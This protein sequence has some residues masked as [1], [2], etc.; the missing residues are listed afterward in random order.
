[1]IKVVPFFLR[2]LVVQV[3]ILGILGC[4]G[5]PNHPTQIRFAYQNRIAD[6]AA[7]VAV[8]QDSFKSQGLSVKPLR[9]DSG[10]ACAEALFTGSA[11]LGTMGDAAA[12]T[13]ITRNPD[14]AIIASHATGEHRHRL[15]VKADSPIRQPQDLAGKVVAVKK[16]TSTHGGFLT[17]LTAKGLNAASM[18]VKDLRPADVPDALFAGSVDAFVASE[19]TPSLAE[20]RGARQI[21]TMGGLGNQ[22]PIL[23]VASR[24]F[25]AKHNQE[26]VR[27]LQTLAQAEAFIRQ[28]PEP[29]AAMVAKATGL[30]PEM[31][32]A[33]MR[34]HRFDLSLGPEIVASLEHLAKFLAEQQK[35]P[36]AP[37]LSQRLDAQYLR[38]A[39]GK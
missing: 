17:Y 23:I 37:P 8:A 22:Y 39:M 31:T 36:A 13:A 7:I 25:L 14:L 26:V 20:S 30:T 6:A 10:P 34:H 28:Q 15:M 38:D 21:A 35:I 11:D 2:L 29:A 1:M 33:A 12:I 9:F 3:L 5:A 4:G 16:G 19:P 18:Q 24:G 27:F 32:L